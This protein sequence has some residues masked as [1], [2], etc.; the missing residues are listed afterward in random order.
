[1]ALKFVVDTSIW[2]DYLENRS[3]R[4]RP[5]GEFALRFLNQCK[6]EGWIILLPDIV[7]S[8]LSAFYGKETTSN[9]IE[10]FPETIK[11]VMTPSHL[12]AAAKLIATA[13]SV[14]PND[15]LIALLAR[16]HKARVVTRDRHFQELQHIAVSSVPELL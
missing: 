13:R 15:A 1:M 3:D 10:S 16:L 4:L 7:A 14:P 9:L 12:F 8:E 2:I 5:L 11:R 6:Q